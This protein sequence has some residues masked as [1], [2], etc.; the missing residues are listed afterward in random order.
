MDCKIVNNEYNSC[1]T[2]FSQFPYSLTHLL[3]YIQNVFYNDFI[4]QILIVST[5][6]G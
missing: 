1:V 4:K 2:L 6:A 5:I 3:D